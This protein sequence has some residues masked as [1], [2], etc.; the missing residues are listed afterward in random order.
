MIRWALLLVYFISL[1]CYSNYA[2]QF[3]LTVGLY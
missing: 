1:H 3:R 2:Q